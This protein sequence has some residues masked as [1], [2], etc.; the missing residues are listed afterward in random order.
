V[1]RTETMV[2]EPGGWKVHYRV[3]SRAGVWR[4][5]ALGLQLVC[6]SDL[7]GVCQGCGVFGER[8]FVPMAAPDDDLMWLCELCVVYGIVGA[9]ALQ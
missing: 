3:R 6:R 7:N 5:A 9:A 2:M 1:T 4:I 8:V